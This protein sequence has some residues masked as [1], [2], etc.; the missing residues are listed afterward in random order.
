MTQVMVG[1]D[2]ADLSRLALDEL[3]ALSDEPAEAVRTQPEAA[4]GAIAVIGMAGRVAECEDLAAFWRLLSE[5]RAALR[6]LPAA[7]AADVEAFLRLKGAQGAHSKTLRAAYLSEVDKFDHRFFGLARQEANLINPN[8]RLFLE[9]AWTALEHAGY[10][11]SSVKGSATGVYVGF[12]SDFGEDYRRLIATHAPDAPEVAVAGNVK[13]I[14]A[15]RIAYHLD[16]RGPSLLVDTACSSGLVAVHLACRALRNGECD[17]ALAGAVK[18][19]LIPVAEDGEAGV[20]IKDI[21]D[22]IAHD[23]RTRT[24]DD[25]CDGTSAAEGVIALVLKPLESALRDGDTIHAVIRGSAVNQDGQSVGITAPNSAAQESLIVRAWRDAQT[26]AESVS[27]IE[28]HG[29]ATRLG[30]PVE[31]SGIQR[32]FRHH[33]KRRQFCAVGSVKS[34]IGHMDNAAGLAGLVKVILSM[35]HR[36]LPPTLNFARPNRSIAFE[37]SPL[38]V[39]DTLRPWHSEAGQPLRAGI[40][41]FGLSGTNCHVVLESAPA[42]ERRPV[43]PSGPYLLPLSARTEA[44]LRLLVEAYRAHV[45]QHDVALEDLCYTAAVGR[46]HHPYRL[47]FAFD[48][49]AGLLRLFD[50]F[51]QQGAGVQSAGIAYGCFKLVNDG[52]QRDRGPGELTEGERKHLDK[53]AAELVARYRRAHAADQPAL[54]SEA[55]ALYTRGAEIAW[56]GWFE[57]RHGRRIPLPTY[58]FSRTRCWVETSP[59]A[60]RLMTAP[61]L[62]NGSHPLVHRRAVCTQGLRVYQSVLGADSH[63]ELA[64]HK[65]QGVHVLPGTAFIEMM[66]EAAGDAAGAEPS[67]ARLENLVFVRPLVLAAGERREVHVLVQQEGGVR[68]VRIVSA[69]RPNADDWDTHAEATLG[70]AAQ[71]RPTAVDLTALQGPLVVPLSFA[72]DEDVSKG[73]DIGERWNL[74]F[75][76]GWTNAARDEF[77][78]RLALPAGYSGEAALYHCHPA[79]LD[80][81]VNAANHRVGDGGLYL[82][83]SYKRLEVYDRLPAECHVHLRRKTAPASKET[84]TFDIDIFDLDGVLRVQAV[85]YTIKRVADVELVPARAHPRSCTRCGSSPARL[86]SP[87]QQHRPSLSCSWGG[88]IRPQRRSPLRCASAAQRSSKPRSSNFVQARSR[89]STAC[90]SAAWCTQPQPVC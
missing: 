12:S 11:G 90:A 48:D 21:Q 1:L 29:T 66:L 51:L 36:Q 32:A 71:A 50:R 80:T 26:P 43:P 67:R 49:A 16:L 44:A 55:L 47:A 59:A 5:G 34:N 75:R 87:P 82:P 69:P 6:D 30:D 79:L 62:R 35:Q 68:T 45:V 28:A 63:W 85:D 17:M 3:L 84:V 86:C 19:D 78:V 53:Q 77:L 38:Y 39:N 33:T 20:G 40:N 23:G 61:A 88:T 2:A 27:Y 37:H 83:L 74:S 65:V 81:A 54:V 15:S 9:T 70:P 46:M 64:D 42:T 25:S 58:P 52:K 56:E 60:E 76:E 10:G 24:F 31:V 4:A 57:G 8:Q 89:A 14:I 41:A 22:T 18:I 13:S 72:R 7:R 73:L